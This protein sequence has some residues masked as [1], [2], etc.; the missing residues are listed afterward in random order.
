MRS[1]AENAVKRIEGVERVDNQIEVLPV[2]FHD[3]RLRLSLSG[4]STATLR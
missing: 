3:D 4:R 2:S 1:D